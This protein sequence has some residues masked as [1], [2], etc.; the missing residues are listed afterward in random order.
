MMQAARGLAALTERPEDHREYGAEGAMEAANGI[1][2][3]VRVLLDCGGNPRMGELQQ[4]RAA[5][6]QENLIDRGPN[7]PASEPAAA[8]R[9]RVS[10]RSRL[11]VPTIS[12]GSCSVRAFILVASIPNSAETEREHQ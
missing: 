12:S 1:G 11:S 7:T 9:T 6:S 10:S 2:E 3:R 4:Q 5:R 8:P